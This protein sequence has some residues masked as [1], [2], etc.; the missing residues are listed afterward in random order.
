VALTVA[1]L[2]GL[3]GTVSG[4]QIQRQVTSHPVVLVPGTA[5]RICQVM[6]SEMDAR[7]DGVSKR[8]QRSFNSEASD[9]ILSQVFAGKGIPTAGTL[10]Q[11]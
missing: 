1:N 3:G 11:P 9:S 7:K 10:N 5:L 2:A 6:T 4:Q 8:G